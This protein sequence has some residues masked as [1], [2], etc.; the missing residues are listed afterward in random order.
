MNS[1][2][3]LFSTTGQG[4]H[5]D[6]GKTEPCVWVRELLLLR[7][8]KPGKEHVIRRISLRP[9]LN[10]LWARPRRG[11]ERPRLGEPGVFGHASG[12]TTFCR[13]LRH[14]LGEQHFGNE[15]LRQRIRNRFNSG[16]VVGEVMLSGEPWLVCRPV[17]VGPHPFVVRNAPVS[18]LFDEGLRREPLQTYLDELNRLVMEP[19]P[20]ATFATSPDPIEWPHLLQWLA[21]DQECRFAALTDFRHSSSNSDSPDM[22][23]EDRHFLFRAVVGLV[24]T[25][26]Q[27]ELE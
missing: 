2:P 6:A 21:R 8:F 5:P 14:V 19:L 1:Q 27:E 15:D 3:E 16:W 9:G 13:L 17:A 18:K 26:E 11:G 24:E 4:F 22:E 23:V 25:A 10:I 20:V 12:K 7:E